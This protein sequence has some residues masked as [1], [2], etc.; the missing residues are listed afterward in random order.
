[1]NAPVLQG[2]NHLQTS[3]IADVAETFK[4]MPS[5]RALQN[6]TLAGAI[7]Q[8][9]PLLQF[10]YTV[11]RLLRMNLGHTPVV[12]KLSAAHG[13]AKM[14]APVIGLVNVCH[15]RCDSALSHN[16]VRFAQQ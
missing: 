1:M 16:G 2:A 5:K 7:K 8:S 15:R 3:A 6:L 13:V 9:T 14:R 10:T 12:Q 11:W 4:R